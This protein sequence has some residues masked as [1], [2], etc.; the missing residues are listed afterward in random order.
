MFDKKIDFDKM[1]EMLAHGMTKSEVARKF[2]VNPSS[3]TKALNKLKKHAPKI[4]ALEKAGRFVD[5]QLNI[6]EQYQETMKSHI[7]LRDG[8]EKYI[9]E[10]DRT[11]FVE[12]QRRAETKSVEGGGPKE[13][14]GEKKGKGSKTKIEQRIE[15]FD[16]T[17]DPKLLLVQV[18]RAIKELMSLQVDII[19]A[20]AD[21]RIIIGI[22]NR[23]IEVM[24][25]VAP[26]AKYEI[27]EILK[28]D[29]LIRS[30][31]TFDSADQTDLRS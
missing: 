19:M 29:Q 4:V 26:E 17:T 13:D 18:N 25:R 5:S 28:R 23:I 1:N 22:L 16:F 7:R 11:I 15:K 8:L 21:P 27:E 14:Q 12:M 20:C 6:M 24:G 3:I 2:K 30:V 10:G 31:I 9:Y